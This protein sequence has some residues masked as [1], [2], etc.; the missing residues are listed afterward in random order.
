MRIVSGSPFV[1]G[2]RRHLALAAA[3]IRGDALAWRSPIEDTFPDIL[4]R[5]GQPTCVLATGDPFHFGIGSV[6][7]RV[8]PAR[9][10]ECLPQPSAFSLAAARL[11]WAVQDCVC[12]SLHGRDLRRLIPHLQARMR[13]LTLSWDGETP[14][15]AAKLLRHLGFGPSRLYVCEALGGG[16]ERIRTATA[17]GFDLTDIADLN[18]V[19]IE[20]EPS[21]DA[22]LC[23][24]TPG[25]PDDW[26]EHD[27]QITKAPIRAITLSALA[28]RAGELLWDVGAG[29]G[30][31]SVEWLLA[32]PTTE[33]I[34]IEQRED[35]AA[36]V[37]RNAETWGV[38]ERLTLR[39]GSAPGALDGLP[40]PDAVFIGGGPTET[41]LLD[42]CLASLRPG[43]RLVANAVTLE[44][45]HV[46]GA[47]YR[48]RGGDLLSFAAAQAEPV[49]RFQAMKP[50]MP[51]IQ[52]RFVQK[53]AGAPS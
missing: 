24:L 18:T 21:A 25:L 11:G 16:A 15:A 40:L 1:V 34:A 26:F 46:L 42:R 10:I 31:V 49:G 9:E 23:P 19:A 29:S 36:R 51:V 12:V 7:A 45:Q 2:G 39:Q 53:P 22:R 3:A 4:A 32:G 38:A 27:G 8:I 41:G 37:T 20:L 28:P 30:S 17:D 47:A 50:A 48:D 35:R 14:S 43:G 13:V 6:L 52:W 44:S 33:A 5:R